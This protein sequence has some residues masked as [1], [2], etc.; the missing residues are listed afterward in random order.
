MVV[1]PA[2]G[3]YQHTLVNALMFYCKGRLSGTTVCSDP[4][5]HRI[6]KDT[7]GTLVVC[8]TDRAHKALASQLAVHSITR[9]YRAIIHGTLSEDQLTIEGAHRAVIRRNE[10]K[11]LLI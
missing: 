9:K 5:V 8:K 2:A 3:H 1:H 4:L 6:D 7:T 10:R 11:W